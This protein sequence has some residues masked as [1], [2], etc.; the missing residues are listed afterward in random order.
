MKKGIV[1][2]I[3]F[4]CLFNVVNAQEPLSFEK[5]ITVDSVGKELIY[6]TI[7]QW[8]ATN[9]K[10]KHILEVDDRETGLMIANLATDYF[11]KGFAYTSYCG[12]LQ[13]SIRTQIKD[14]RFKVIITNF[15]HA[16]QGLTNLGLLTS[17]EK[18]Y[19]AMNSKWDIAVWNDLKE[20]AT[21][22]ADNTF[23]LFEKMNFKS[24]NW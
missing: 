18:P 2:A 4:F 24:D 10:S 9:Y 3:M 8:Y 23:M 19:K 22:L 5:V 15:K 20:K 7:K 17:A 12:Q 1:T 16:P 11:L 13:Y 21:V 6:S 14:G